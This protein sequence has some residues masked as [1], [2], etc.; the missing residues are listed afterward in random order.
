MDAEETIT[1]P[2]APEEQPRGP[3]PRSAVFGR[4]VIA[5]AGVA[6]VVAAGLVLYTVRD[7]LVEVLIATFL[8][9]SLDPPVRWMVRHG[10]RRGYAVAVIF[11]VALA[12]TGLFLWAFLPP[13]IRQGASLVSDFPGFVADLRAR[14][15]LFAS[16]DDRFHVHDQV[17][18]WIAGL[19]NDAGHDALA[20]GQRFTGAAATVLLVA[21]LTVYLM[22][23]LPRLRSGLLSI[24]P[25]RRQDGVDVVLTLI[26][27]KVGSYMIGNVL[28]SGIAGASA[29]VVLT[30][31]GVPFAFPLAVVVALTDL[32]PMVGATLGAAACVVAALATTPLWPNTTLVALF[33]VVYQQIENYLIAPRVLR[34]SV[35][36]PALLVLL[37][38]LIGGRLLGLVGALMAIPCAAV[39]REIAIPA[40]RRRRTVVD[41]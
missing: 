26:T 37:A 6:T 28:I 10:M 15:P 5:A 11:V 19:P 22:L 36:M 30:A 27:D 18:A 40:M 35:Q 13:L 1:S 23:D 2:A 39:I 31:L 14:S 3:V 12:L 7:V 20:F 33:F 21:V 16:F 17:D 34:N 8:A 32:I 41:E 9:I 25:R 38:A 4:A 24:F 29:L